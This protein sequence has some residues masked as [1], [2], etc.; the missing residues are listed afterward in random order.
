MT[1][2]ASALK[3]L[4]R[5]AAPEALPAD[6]P[7]VAYS[8]TLFWT[9]QARAWGTGRRAAVAA[10]LGEVLARPE[11]EPNAY[12]RRYTVPGLDES[13]HSGESLLAL[14]KVLEALI[15]SGDG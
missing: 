13:A 4:L 7:R 5:R 8:Y 2:F 6:P 3:K 9:R 11:F 15:V 10:A 1:S 12:E 14:E